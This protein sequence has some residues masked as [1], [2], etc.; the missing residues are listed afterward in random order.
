MLSIHDDKVRLKAGAD[1]VEF[2]LEKIDNRIFRTDLTAVEAPG[3]FDETII[4]PYGDVQH[5][6]TAFAYEGRYYLDVDQ[7]PTASPTNGPVVLK[8]GGL[9]YRL[10]LVEG[11]DGRKY[12]DYEANQAVY[13]A[14]VVT[15]KLTAK[16]KGQG[17][18]YNLRLG[19]DIR[20]IIVTLTENNRALASQPESAVLKIRS[21]AGVITAR[22]LTSKGSG[23]W[24]Y[25]VADEDFEELVVGT[26]SVE[27]YGHWTDGTNGTFPT[28]GALT[29]N[30]FSKMDT[31][32]D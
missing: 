5:E 8:V 32:N 29:L 11:S 9:P 14:G 19:D 12:L 7:D 16:F 27:V 10:V 4:L 24:A 30:V 20:D 2:G 13:V 21:E 3:A 1:W 17:K 18:T 26:Y 22:E 15:T 31:S 23:D 28:S 6:L 25:R